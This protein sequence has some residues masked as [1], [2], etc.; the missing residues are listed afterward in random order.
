[1]M[2]PTENFGENY[3]P[4]RSTI[5]RK[6][7]GVVLIAVATTTLLVATATTWIEIKSYADVKKAE[8]SATAFVFSAA[9]AEPLAQ[10]KHIDIYR[11]LRAIGKIPHFAHASVLDTTGRRVAEL[12]SAV[13]LEEES[14]LPIFLRK[15]F[16]VQ[17]PIVKSGKVIGQLQ[18]LA[19]TS[20]LKERL[21]RHLVISLLAALF[22]ATVGILIAAKL[23]RRIT[24]P[25]RHLTQSMLDVQQT[26]DFSRNVKF[27]SDDETGLLVDTFNGMMVQ[28][29]DRDERLA[30]HR[31]N[32]E[33]T[34]EERTVDLRHAKDAAEHANAAKSDFLATMS[35]EIR[36]PM[37]GMLVMA[38][39]L[40]SAELTD[41][42]RRYADVVVKSGQSLLAII[43]DILDFSKIESGK[44]DLEAVA[45]DPGELVD[46]VLSLF[47]EKASGK[48]VDLSAYVAADVPAS[49]EGDPV[50]LNQIL[51]NLVNNALKFTEDGHVCI[52]VT[53][54]K[55]LSRR[56]AIGLRFAVSDTGIGIPADKLDTIFESFS[57]ADQ[58]TTRKFGGTGLGLAICKRLVSAMDG[59]L[60]V[61]STFGEGSEFSFTMKTR[62][63]TE[64]V[65]DD[66]AGS[67]ASLQSAIVSLAGSATVDTMM[68]YLED[69][70]I[71]ARHVEPSDFTTESIV[72][73][74]I[75]FA[76]P[77]LIAKLPPPSESTGQSR[78]F[79]VCV[80]QMGDT[81]S[82]AAL[83][84]GSA[85]DILMR[86]I[87]RKGF[88]ALIDRLAGG[89]PLGRKAL[90]RSK[91]AETP[92]FTGLNVLVADDS[93]VNREVVIE[94]LK[95]LDVRADV[96]E[97]GQQALEQATRQNY[98][99]IFMDCS[100]PVMDGFEATRRIRAAEQERGSK[101][102]P[103]V[104]LTAHVAGT[105][106]DAWQDAGMDA[107]LTKPFRLTDLSGC[108][109]TF[110]GP[111]EISAA[112]P[113]T[114][115]PHDAPVVVRPP[116]P[117][118]E[119]PDDNAIPVID[120]D[121]LDGVAACSPGAGEALVLKV[122]GLFESH[123][124]AALLKLAETAQTDSLTTIGEA[125][126]ALK[127]MARNIGANRL[128]EACGVLEAEARSG[129]VVELKSRLETIHQCVVDVLA[130]IKRRKPGKDGN[131][132]TGS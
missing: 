90:Q 95:Q 50:R 93:P 105:S 44:M 80:S 78:P 111:G 88:G 9:V 48:G 131:R 102:V 84:A 74:A 7:I 5:G 14:D 46:D 58:S 115:V 49:V 81:T 98:D 15:T 99:L 86:P 28:I 76:D 26:S 73:D 124:P 24:N 22:A 120:D 21:T 125:A 16:D 109:E 3:I 53:T 59:E 85:H 47:W 57:Q 4:T 39:L 69:R 87:S 128:G 33:R 127:S 63:L 65:N 29:R 30:E 118:A 38:E 64:G 13:A 91:A 41:R 126:H 10:G 96:V 72:D 104:A 52:T 40:A 117:A 77:S 132:Q 68:R 97:D 106:A 82:D 55:H 103:I 34:V 20:D 108:F 56:E 2:H 42:H 18:V 100:M 43:N 45:L 32:L 12:G 107:Y 25:L 83:E 31:D 11:A 101:P 75:V 6:L 51:S 27:K 8:L 119:E 19:D 66:P 116:S 37:N 17:V 121:V 113:D 36:T 129:D 62:D 94:A 122:L 67:T 123:A 54:A 89:K 79:A 23:Q 71:V 130:E 92:R 114:S 61:T 60:G 35:H 110:V 112:E 1:M 70:H